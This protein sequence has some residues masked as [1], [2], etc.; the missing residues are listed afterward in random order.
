MERRKIELPAD[1]EIIM[2]LKAGDLLLLSG[3]VYTARDAAHKKI[4]GL[5][6]SG[7]LLPF[8]ISGQAI[9]YAG[10]CPARPGQVIGSAGPTTSG[11][12]DLYT[13]LLLEN[14]LKVMIGKGKRSEKVIQSIKTHK[15]VYLGATGGAGALISRCITSSEVVAWPDLGT[16]AVHRLQIKDL[17]VIVLVDSL[18]NDWY[19]IGL[20]E[21]AGR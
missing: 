2:S 12:M 11:R 14:G 21:W 17:P 15:A 16:E 9:Y 13:P 1:N 20:S 10:P 18:G 19:E 6:Q 7:D 3:M 8:A 4:A 5:L